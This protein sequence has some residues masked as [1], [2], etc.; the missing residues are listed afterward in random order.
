M[1]Y[2]TVKYGNV[3][4]KINGFLKKKLDNIKKIKKK[5]WDCVIIVDGIERGGKSTLAMLCGWYVSD[6]KLKFENIASASDDAIKKL[7]K[8]PDGSV[9]IIDEGSLVFS[10]KDSM[11][12]EQKKLIKILNVIGQ[13]NMVLI[14]VLPTIIDLNRF[15]AVQRSRFLL[16]VYTDTK[17]NRGRFCYF[18]E[19]KKKLLYEI[20]KKNFN[21]YSKPRSKITGMFPE[22]FPW[23]DKYEEYKKIKRKSLFDAFHKDERVDDIRDVKKACKKELFMNLEKYK[24]RVKRELNK[25]NKIKRE[26][27]ALILGCSKSTISEFVKGMEEITVSRPEL[28]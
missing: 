2:E 23:P 25:R 14:I 24:D 13:K 5:N 6:G 20:G 22:F 8:L 1:T 4:T 7:E 18:G 28:I 27:E 21:S 11:K 15:V 26:T 3:E 16:H 10:S 19:K 12:R 9:L 17:L